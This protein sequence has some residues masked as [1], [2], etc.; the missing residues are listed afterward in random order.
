MEKRKKELRARAEKVQEGE[1]AEVR[2]GGG[3]GVIS[4]T[5]LLLERRGAHLQDELA[6]KLQLTRYSALIYSCFSHFFR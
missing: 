4:Q 1:N 2:S 6:A 3:S 5:P